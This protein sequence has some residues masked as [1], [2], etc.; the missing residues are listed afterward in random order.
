MKY[1]LY[2]AKNCAVDK[3]LCSFES[4]ELITEQ[5]AESIISKHFEL[6]SNQLDFVVCELNNEVA[7]YDMNVEDWEDENLTLKYLALPCS[8]RV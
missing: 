1:E 3:L 4:E 8:V 6:P 7:V 5:N 2:Q